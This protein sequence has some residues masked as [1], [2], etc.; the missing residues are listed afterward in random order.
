MPGPR[1]GG[2]PRFGPASPMMRRDASVMSTVTKMK[3]WLL[4][5][6]F[7]ML[8]NGMGACSMDGETSWKEEVLLHD[9]SNYVSE[10]QAG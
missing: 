10:Q 2:Y 5:I 8:G 3:A 4:G 9:D 7:M 6:S 1:T